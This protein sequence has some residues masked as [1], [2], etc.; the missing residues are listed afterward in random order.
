MADTRFTER[1]LTF[2]IDAPVRDDVVTH[3]ATLTLPE[4]EGPFPAALLVAGS[5]PTD[6]N[7][8][9][10][11]LPGSIGTLRMLAHLL[12]EHGFASLRYD[13]LGSGETGLGPYDIDDIAELGFT[14]AFVDPAAEALR[15]LADEDTVDG[16]KIL[17]IGHSDGALVG[18]ELAVRGAGVHG[19]ALI[20]PLAVRLLDLLT[21][22]IAAQLDAVTAAGALPV[23][24]AD[25]LRVAL[26]GA[27]E[28]LRTDGTV[29][30]DLP[31][32]LQNAGIVQA[33]AKALAEEDSLDPRELA[34]KL[35]AGTP[36]LTSASEKDVQVRLSDVDGL[37]AALTHTAL[38]PVRMRTANHV[39][40]DV[41]DAQSTGAD[42][43]QDL[44]WSREFTEPFG[45]WLDSIR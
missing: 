42:Y 43:T 25:E 37:D 36:V 19:L 23:S 31:E 28:S 6:R 4:G 10:A 17:V 7:G 35:P 12:A 18:L 32:P 27:V 44:P 34:G 20:E 15:V 22:Q 8:D 1:D 41:G 38:V 40:K 26:A 11:L 45:E 9:S 30:D 29:S 2:D 39:L 3:H 13:K 24:A 16:S 21:D 33:N 14:S 5:G